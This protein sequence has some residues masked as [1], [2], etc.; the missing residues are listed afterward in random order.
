[1][2]VASPPPDALADVLTHEG[3][4]L[5]VEVVAADSAS[6]AGSISSSVMTFATMGGTGLAWGRGLT[7]VIVWWE[8][9]GADTLGDVM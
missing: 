4:P 2:P 5:G 7:W 6:S 1:M 9:A 3:W 8:E